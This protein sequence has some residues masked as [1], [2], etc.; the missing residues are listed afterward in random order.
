MYVYNFRCLLH[1]Y[2]YIYVYLSPD[3]SERTLREPFMSGT[4]AMLSFAMIVMASFDKQETA[5]SS[6]HASMY[7][8][9]VGAHLDMKRT[10]TP[11][12]HA[13]LKIRGLFSH[14]TYVSVPCTPLLRPLV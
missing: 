5:C 12:L 3:K 10:F 13:A 1:V 11:F 2:L 9:Y 8:S 6:M 14:T 4:K 7:A